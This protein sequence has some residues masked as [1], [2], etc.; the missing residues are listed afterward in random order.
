ML[1]DTSE[2]RKRQKELVAVLR[3]L[4]NSTYDSEDVIRRFNDIY[5]E[6]FRHSY[7]EIFQV[8]AEA[9]QECPAGEENLLIKN[10][11]EILKT[12]DQEKRYDENT[13]R[14]LFKLWDHV[15][16]ET[17]RFQYLTNG[18]ESRIK[19]ISQKSDDLERKLNNIQESAQSSAHQMQ[20]EFVSILGIFAAI[21]IAFFG[22]MN[23]ITSAVASMKENNVAHVVLVT[24]IAALAM[25]NAIF[26]MMCYIGRL[27][28]KKLVGWYIVVFNIFLI[29]LPILF[30]GYRWCYQ[31]ATIKIL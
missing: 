15:N 26:L 13:K 5:K 17:A 3:L 22:G 1:F 6:D 10:L 24:T 28:G 16:L 21:I 29:F 27:I 2:R 19:A 20:R 18:P 14:G 7:S 23:F 11:G 30:I 9:I 4:N 8:I 31:C 25:S 12:L